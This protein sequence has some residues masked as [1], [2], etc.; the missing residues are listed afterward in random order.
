MFNI[1]VVDAYDEGNTLSSYGLNANT[2]LGDA[3]LNLALEVCPITVSPITNGVE[4]VRLSVDG[5]LISSTILGV[6]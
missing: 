4:F 6:M 2:E 1:S 5:S 3:T